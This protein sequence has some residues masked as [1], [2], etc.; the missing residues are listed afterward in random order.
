MKEQMEKD[1]GVYSSIQGNDSVTS[2]FFISHSPSL[3]TG[4]LP[5]PNPEVSI[6]KEKRGAHIHCSPLRLYSDK[7]G[8][9]GPR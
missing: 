2:S 4:E 9:G 8:A 1:E 3:C 5:N 6:P 7:G